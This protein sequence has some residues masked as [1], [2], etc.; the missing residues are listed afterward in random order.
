MRVLFFRGSPP[1]SMTSSACR[2]AMDLSY[3][4]GAEPT[5]GTQIAAINA[6]AAARRVRAAL[7]V[8]YVL[9][10]TQKTRFKDLVRCDVVFEDRVE[11][12]HAVLRALHYF[13]DATAFR[14]ADDVI[15]IGGDPRKNKTRRN[16][17][18]MMV[19]NARDELRAMRANLDPRPDVGTRCY[20]GAQWCNVQAPRGVSIHSAYDI[21]W[22]VWEQIFEAHGLQCV[23]VW[24]LEPEEL[25]GG[26]TDAFYGIQTTAVGQNHVMLL[27]DGTAGY[28]HR[29]V[30][31]TKY[32]LSNGH[33]GK[34]FNL[35]VLPEGQWGILRRYTIFRSHRPARIWQAKCAVDRNTAHVPTL[36]G[37]C[38]KVPLQHWDNLL[39]WGLA[40]GDEKFTFQAL[41]A[42]A[43]ALRH[44]LIVG[45]NVVHGGWTQDAVEQ[46]DVVQTAFVVCAALRFMRTQSLSLALRRLK[47]EQGR[48]W[49]GE[50]IDRLKAWLG[51]PAIRLRQ[52]LVTDLHNLRAGRDSAVPLLR[53]LPGRVGGN[54]WPEEDTDEGPEFTPEEPLPPEPAELLAYRTALQAQTCTAGPYAEL[55]Q[56]TLD[57]LDA[58]ECRARPKRTL[59]EGPPGSGKSTRFADWSDDR[60]ANTLV[61]VPTKKQ[62]ADWAQRGFTAHTPQRA[63]QQCVGYPLVIVDEVS[64]VHPGVVRALE[65]HSGAAQLY[66]VGDLKQIAF[67]DFEGLGVEF[68]LQRFYADWEKETLTVTHRCPVDVTKVLGRYYEGITTTNTRQVSI[69]KGV[70]NPAAQHLCY[71]QGTKSKLTSQHPNVLTVHEAQG[72]TYKAVCL[73]VEAQDATLVRTSRAHN[74]VAITRHTGSL[75]VCEQGTTALSEW[76][77]PAFAVCELAEGLDAAPVTVPEDARATVSPADEAGNSIP[78]HTGANLDDLGVTFGADLG[79]ERITAAALPAAQRTAQIQLDSF[80]TLDVSKL[81]LTAVPA[82]ACRFSRPQD[83]AAA[84]A[85]VLSRITGTNKNCGK[86]EAKVRGAALRRA[87]DQWLEPEDAVVSPDEQFLRLAEALRA[88]AEKDPELRRLLA[89]EDLVDIIRVENHLKQQAKFAGEPLRKIKAGQGIDAWSKK[90]NL[91]IGPFIRAAQERLLRRLKPTVMMIL[92]QSDADVRD[93]IRS[94][95]TGNTCVCN[96]FTEFDSTQNDGTTR[97]ECLLL[98]DLGVP[99][100]IV[101]TYKALRESA[102]VHANGVVTDA[103]YARMSG[104]ANT[105][106]GNTVVTMA[107]NALLFP[108]AF[109]WA[110]F[111]GDDSIICNPRN[112][113]DPDIISHQTG[114][115]CKIEEQHVSEFVGLLISTDHVFPDLRRRVG[116]LTGRGYPGDPMARDQFSQ[117]VRDTLALI[118]PEST[119]AC[120]LLNA[121]AHHVSPAEAQ[122]WYDVLIAC[123]EGLGKPNRV[124]AIEARLDEEI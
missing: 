34:N 106:F 2:S 116:K 64:L 89:E 117:S 105:L 98:A 45:S 18:C 52:F 84:A 47:H 72:G 62:K 12:T 83:K 92:H 1:M 38:I 95:H 68:D 66:C 121:L 25:F 82:P 33:V 111:K 32:R 51:I 35:A 113:S 14:H 5:W 123:V 42:Y 61:V 96:D 102:R 77:D 60:K 107:V 31:W 93:W 56:Q 4:Q 86:Q 55:A 103:A 88:A 74:L 67:C 50:L 40:R 118:T 100:P 29:T 57:F 71:T 101:N 91:V 85:A 44:R 26:T 53:E 109:D 54:F 3:P 97:F 27:D 24:L 7:H 65:R 78:P 79:V 112:R 20:G 15:D 41:M 23:D 10:Q 70:C 76:L 80:P 81:A 124:E 73:H 28:E 119:E 87:F 90:A 39:S 59:I 8:P 37:G 11:H 46:H 108:G 69:I 17:V 49:F 110:A 6:G 48:G 36:A 9:T 120:I 104:E 75:V 94:V 58:A 30:E 13:A 63:L 114:M 19:D 22:E 99:K 115:Q 21:T 122:V 16:H 43:R